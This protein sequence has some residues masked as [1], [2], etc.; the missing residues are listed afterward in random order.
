M[1]DTRRL[2]P[3]PSTP[4]S[5]P[6]GTLGAI[7]RQRC[8]RCHEGRIFRRRITMNWF[9]PVCE[10]RFMR[11]PGYTT[12][13]IELS[14]LFTVPILV[15]GT[16]FFALVIGLP[17]LWAAGAATA[18]FIAL[19]PLVFRYSRVLWIYLDQRLDPGR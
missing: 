8:P 12:V 15:G 18:L 11:E 1:R 14:Y 13:A 10:L 2:Y 6:V 17:I 9:C 3:P 4:A 7:L 5:R 16:A 19:S